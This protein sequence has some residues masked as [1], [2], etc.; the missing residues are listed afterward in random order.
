MKSRFAT[1][2]VSLLYLSVA[3]VFGVVHHHHDDDCDHDGCPVGEHKDCA[4]C[5]WQLNAVTD[6]PTVVPLIS[7]CVLETPL[8]TFDFI[9]YSA[10]SFSFSPSRAPPLASA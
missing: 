4:A 2:V 9:S 1:A 6:V 3:L 7:P 8:Q 5:Q 10:P